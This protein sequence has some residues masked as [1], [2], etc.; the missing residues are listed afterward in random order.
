MMLH[1]ILISTPTVASRRLQQVQEDT[2]LSI[3]TFI[4]R[5][6]YLFRLSVMLP[7]CSLLGI[8]K[9]KQMKLS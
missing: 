3:C 8:V 7:T 9:E 6:F 4:S 2:T 5:Y 1:I